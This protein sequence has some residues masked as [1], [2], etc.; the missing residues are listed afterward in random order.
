MIHKKGTINGINTTGFSVGDVLLAHPEKSGAFINVDDLI[1]M[2]KEKHK[3][4]LR[5]AFIVGQNKAGI[6]ENMIVMRYFKTWYKENY[7]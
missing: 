3:E 6:F 7:K 5:K 1:V 2:S 4:E